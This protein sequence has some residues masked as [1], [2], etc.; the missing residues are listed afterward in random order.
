MA[1]A[2]LDEITL[3]AS[4]LP[5]VRR[6]RRLSHQLWGL[7][8]VTRAPPH[9]ALRAMWHTQDAVKTQYTSHT[10][11]QRHKHTFGNCIYI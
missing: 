2:G 7:Q 3:V 10:H 8:R 11:I 1:P 6:S 4:L 5:S 9:M